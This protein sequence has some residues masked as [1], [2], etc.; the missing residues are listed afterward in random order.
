[1]PFFLE[2]CRRN[3][4]INWLLFSDCGIPQDLPKNVQVEEIG[5]TE[6]CKLV[7]SRLAID[8]APTNAYKLCDIKPALGYIHEDRLHGYDFWAFGDIDVIYG[9]LR[10]YF[11][12]ERLSRND[13]FSTHER[14]VAGHLC[15][16][17]NTACKRELFMQIKNWRARFTDNEH[18][19]LDE[20]AFSRLFLWRKNFPKPLFKLV[21]KFNPLRRRSEFTEAFSTPGGAIKWHDGSSD[22]PNHWYWRDGRLSNDRDGDRCFPYFHFLC[23]KQDWWKLAIPDPARVRQIAESSS[24]IIDQTGFHQEKS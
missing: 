7:S 14:R 5:F 16:M 24:W 6:Y 23:W 19:A 8:F 10:A 4:D 13:L 3:A 15:L 17:R 1:M 22:F 20:G 18:H 9:N 2:S 11:T 21:G 12:A